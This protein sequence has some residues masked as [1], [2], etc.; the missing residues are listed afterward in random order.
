MGCASKKTEIWAELVLAFV[1]PMRIVTHLF[2]SCSFTCLV[3]LFIHWEGA[4]GGGLDDMVRLP[5]SQ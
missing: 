1:N 5:F 2:I 3:C 4:Y